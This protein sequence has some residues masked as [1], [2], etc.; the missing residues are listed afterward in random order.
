METK[1]IRIGN[2]IRLAVDLRQYVG[3]GNYLRERE[4]YN[5]E[6]TGYENIDNNPFVNKQ[7]EV[8]YPDQYGSQSG[9]GAST[10]TYA[11]ASTE[12]SIRSV[13]AIL[14]N[15]T[16]WEKILKDLRNKTRFIDRFPIEP[17]LRA[18]HS[19]PYDICNSG[20]PIWRA[21]PV[22]PGFGINHPIGEMYKKRPWFNDAEYRARVT[23]TDQQHVVEVHFPAE[24]QRYTGTYKLIIVAKLYAPGFN[25][26]NLKTVTVDVPGVFELVGTSAEGYDTGI[27]INVNTIID[28]LPSGSGSND[29]PVVG[30]DDIYVNDGS[31]YDNTLLLNRSDDS[32]V[33]IDLS[34][35][36]GWYDID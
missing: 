18:F 8:Y 26:Q 6:D 23:A 33:D 21:M 28:K 32:D 15:T 9:N 12:V 2:D 29:D 24:H 5:P 11:A 30:F 27:E 34:S 10:T 3:G 16:M 4:V 14:V 1:K 7:Y 22:Y 20:Y 19:T 35:I 36:T 31:V 25:D 17:R 13:K